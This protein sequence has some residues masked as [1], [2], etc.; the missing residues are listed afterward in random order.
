LSYLQRFPFDTLKIDKSFVRGQPSGSREIILRSIVDL[1]HDLNM[2]VVAEGVEAEEEA[3][4]LQ[5]LGCEYAQGYLFGTPMSANS[6]SKVLIHE[7][8]AIPA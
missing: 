1:A 6:A 3:A 4:E 7:K 8:R 5:D 2:D